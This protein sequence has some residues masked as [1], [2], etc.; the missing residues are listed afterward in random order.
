[1]VYTEAWISKRQKAGAA[2]YFVATPETGPHHSCLPG[3]EE[4]QGHTAEEQAECSDNSMAIFENHLP[5]QS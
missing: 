2:G 1:M 5:Q 4:C 3:C